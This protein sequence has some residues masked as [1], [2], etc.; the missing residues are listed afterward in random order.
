MTSPTPQSIP[1]RP[2]QVNLFQYV[3][4]PN[5]PEYR[6]ILEIFFEA[7]QRYVIE[8]RPREILDA[9][10]RAGFDVDLR[11]EETLE[12]HLAQLVE[13]GNLTRTHDTAAVLTIQD[14]YR[15]QFVY[16]LT[17][18]GEAAHRAVLEVE[19]AVGKAGSLQAGMLGRI[20]DTFRDLAERAVRGDGRPENLAA[21]FYDLF[22]D[23]DLLTEE[24]NRFIGEIGRRIDAGDESERF[25]FRKQALLAYIGR[26]LNQLHLLE[27]EIAAHLT[28]IEKAGIA[29]LIETA[30]RSPDLPP[31]IGDEDPVEAWRREHQAKWDGIRR[32]FLG[33]GPSSPT[34]SRLAEAARGAVIGLTRALGRLN[35]RQTG[36]ADRKA[37]FLALARWFAACPD[38]D[39]AHDLWRL[40]F[41]LYPARHFHIPE[42]D[43]G[44]ATRGTSWWDA[45]PVYV[46][47]RL[48]QRGA[49]IRLG[50][51]SPIPDL[52]GEKRWIAEIRRREREQ[53]EGALARF[54][55]GGLIQM[56][57]IATL[58]L[59]EFDL[60]LGLLDEIL[61]A[62]R[63]TGGLRKTR[64]RDGRFDL[65][66]TEPAS[67]GRETLV[68]IVTPNGRL[69]CRDYQL[70]VADA[71]AETTSTA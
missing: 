45:E 7:K 54:A 29:A 66:L 46:P 30:S 32:W 60:F 64:T 40:A 51:S 69:R 67:T 71:H 12:R 9:I 58:D 14:F 36:R 26:F 15:R 68:E 56:R 23:F 48:R 10:G 57:Q 52:S 13:W 22:K 39:A 49:A 3:T 27:G 38:D 28:A 34:V 6:S 25:D 20:R 37:D 59:A 42:D 18:V 8:Q 47:I 50:K 17:N 2:N 55:G 41:G 62:P 33:E 65:L 44:L 19:A 53:V 31:A 43:P 63:Q 1:C 24:A 16:H 11:D 21:R 35:D 61:S 70:T 4:V 5:A